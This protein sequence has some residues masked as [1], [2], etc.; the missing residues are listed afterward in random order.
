MFVSAAWDQAGMKVSTKQAK[1]LCLSRN[2]RQCILQASGKH[3]SRWRS[4]ND[5][6]VVFTS[7]GRQNKEIDTRT[8][9]DANTVLHVLSFCGVKNGS[10]QKPQSCEIGV[11]SDPRL[12]SWISGNDWTNVIS[13]DFANN[14]ISSASGRDGIFVKSPWRDASRKSAQLLNSEPLLWIEITAALVRPCVQNVPE[15]ICKARPASY[16][17]RKVA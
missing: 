4:S 5:L 13:S 1:V 16:T 7:G 6:R 12:C 9:S 2:A 15:M 17:H 10:F 14:I 11:C 3:C 8:I